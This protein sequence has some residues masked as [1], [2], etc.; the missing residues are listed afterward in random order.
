MENISNSIYFILLKISK[1]LFPVVQS[2][3]FCFSIQQANK[4]IKLMLPN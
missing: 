2:K 1:I 3:L 4:F